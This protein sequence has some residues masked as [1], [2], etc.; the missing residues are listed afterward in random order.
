MSPITTTAEG[1]RTIGDLAALIEKL[2]GVVEQETT[3]DSRRQ[4]PRCLGA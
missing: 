3:A 2:G 1:E 4:D